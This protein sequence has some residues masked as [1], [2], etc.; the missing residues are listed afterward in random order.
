MQNQSYM[1]TELWGAFRFLPPHSTNTLYYEKAPEH[2]P[3]LKFHYKSHHLW[4]C[5]QQFFHNIDLL[6]SHQ[7]GKLLIQQRTVLCF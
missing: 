7:L 4:Q 6:I 5:S 1:Q 2:S 3:E